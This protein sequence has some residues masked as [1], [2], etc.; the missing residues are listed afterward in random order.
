MHIAAARRRLGH[1]A[2][3]EAGTRAAEQ[4]ILDAARERLETVEA[5]LAQARRHALLRDAAATRTLELTEERG[6]LLEVIRRAEA[7]LADPA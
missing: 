2:G 3:L 7:T 5:E 1:L 4:R 6:R